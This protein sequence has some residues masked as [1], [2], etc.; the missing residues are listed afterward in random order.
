MMVLNCTGTGAWLKLGLE[1]SGMSRAYMSVIRFVFPHGCRA[2]P[3]VV[4]CFVCLF[5]FA[6]F[7]MLASSVQVRGIPFQQTRDRAG[8]SGVTV[9]MNNLSL[10]RM[11]LA[12][13]P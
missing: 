3:G 5:G 10:L 8:L 6:L 13:Q 11:S 2:F 9:I 1:W 12:C 4:F 7:L